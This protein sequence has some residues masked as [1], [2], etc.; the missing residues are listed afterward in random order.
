MAFLYL[1][2][3][4]ILRRIFLSLERLIS[5]TPSRLPLTSA[6]GRLVS[7]PS[8]GELAFLCGR[9]AVTLFFN[10]ASLQITLRTLVPVSRVLASFAYK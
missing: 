6:T 2:L 3:F 1:L 7:S 4:I 10:R 8:L 5:L 9:P